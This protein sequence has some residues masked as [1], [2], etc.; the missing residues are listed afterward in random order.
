MKPLKKFTMMI[1]RLSALPTRESAPSLTH[2][3]SRAIFLESNLISF[4]T[5]I[6]FSTYKYRTDVN[7]VQGIICHAHNMHTT[8]S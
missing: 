5:K 7:T 1:V 8:Q 4:I 6:Y 3:G 2:S